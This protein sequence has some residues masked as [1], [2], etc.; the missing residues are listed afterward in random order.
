M[1]SKATKKHK[2]YSGFKSNFDIYYNNSLNTEL[3]KQNKI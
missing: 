2:G 3:E 1:F